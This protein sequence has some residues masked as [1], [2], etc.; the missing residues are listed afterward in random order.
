MTNDEILKAFLWHISLYAHSPGDQAIHDEL[1]DN[2]RKFIGLDIRM[3]REGLQFEDVLVLIL[4]DINGQINRCDWYAADKNFKLFDQIASNKRVLGSLLFDRWYKASEA[5]HRRGLLDKAISCTIQAEKYATGHEMKYI[6][7]MQRGEIESSMKNRYEFSVNSLSAAL[8]EA[9]QLGDIYVARVYDKLAHMC[10]LR[11][12]ALGMYYL[13][14]AQVIAKRLGDDSIVLENKMARINS[15][16]VLAMRHPQDE[17]LFLDEAKCIL[18]TIDYEKLP[19]LQ[20]KMYYKEL[21]GKIYFDVEPLIEA[22]GFYESVNSIDEICRMCDA[23]IEI[24][25]N[26]NQAAK[27]KPYTDLYRRIVIKR[28][29]KDVSLELNHIN[30]EEEIINGILA[31]QAK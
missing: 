5:Y 13:R 29:K 6:I 11:Y 1:V 28:N 26:H 8:Y 12:A 31:G 24:G 25:V 15:Y 30:Q 3:I 7:L 27:A 9:E 19:M 22:C 17:K 14:K 16:S 10:S 2:A 4:Y 23:I 21:Q 18:A 20:N